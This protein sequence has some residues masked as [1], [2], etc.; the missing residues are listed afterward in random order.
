LKKQHEKTTV[1]M[2]VLAE[3]SK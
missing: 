1:G 3:W 2:F